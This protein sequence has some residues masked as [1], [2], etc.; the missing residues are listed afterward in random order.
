MTDSVKAVIL[1]GGSGNRLWPL[2]RQQ[3]PKQFLHLNGENSLLQETVERLDPLIGKSDVWVVTGE[4]F[5]RGEAYA[6]LKPYHT[7]LEPVGRNTAPAI[8]LAAALFLE[9]G[10]DATLVVLPADHLIRDTKQFQT[11]L[12]EAILAAD[13]GKLVTFGIRPERADTGFGYIQAADPAADA[14]AVRDVIRFTEKPD[15]ETAESFLSAG[16]YFWNSGMFVWRASAIMEEVERFLPDLFQVVEDILLAI[17]EGEDRQQ[18]VHREFPRMPSISIDYGVLEQ[19]DRVCLI[20]CDIGW[21]D[22][23]SWDALFE[24]AKKDVNGNAVDGHV[25]AIDCEGSLLRSGKRLLAAV[26][27]R[28]MCVVETSDALLI[29]PRGESQRVRE[30]VSCLK[31]TRAP[32]QLSHPTV[33][34]PWGSFTVLLEDQCYKIKQIEVHPYEQLSLQMHYYRSE[35]WVVVSGTA[36]VQRGEEMLTIHRNESTYIPSGMKHRLRNPG[37][38]PLKIIEVQSGEYVGEDDIVRFD[39]RYGRKEPA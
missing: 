3:L 20:P 28:D 34:K 21:S 19:S 37:K 27:L 4:E 33:Q 26:G 6:E 10:E 18:V 36:E 16:N 11:H 23:G 5:A 17:R 15:L 2:S 7:I 30:I 29:T 12:S 9:Q 31:E 8:A 25:L 22:I 32:E 14:G 35:H 1:A 38:R 39:D 24:I 13:S